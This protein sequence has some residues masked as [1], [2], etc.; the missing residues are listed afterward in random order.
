MIEDIKEV[1]ISPLLALRELDL[2]KNKLQHLEFVSRLTELEVSLDKNKVLKLSENNLTKIVLQ[3]EV[4]L[5]WLYALD[6]S[7]NKIEKIEGIEKNYPALTVLDISSNLI[8]DDNEFECF[9]FLDNIAE[10]ELDDNP[11]FDSGSED[12]WHERFDFLERIN[13]RR[14]YSVG[15]RE[16]R[17]MAQ[18]CKD[19]LDQDLV[20]PKELEEFTHEI[21]DRRRFDEELVLDEPEGECDLVQHSI[22]K[23]NKIVGEEFARNNGYLKEFSQNYLNDFQGIQSEFYSHLSKASESI[24]DGKQTVNDSLLEIGSKPVFGPDEMKKPIFM[25][26]TMREISEKHGTEVDLKEK[27]PN[28][29]SPEQTTSNKEVEDTKSIS[30]S[31]LFDQKLKSSMVVAEVKTNK[32]RLR[33]Y[34]RD[35]DVNKKPDIS[36][37]HT[38]YQKVSINWAQKD[39]KKQNEEILRMLGR[40]RIDPGQVQ[41]VPPR[42]LKQVPSANRLGS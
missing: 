23:K 39:Y 27:L 25:T 1:E 17:K 35:I 15:E 5:P 16:R 19:M 21:K 42:T 3:S 18:I 40:T 30:S 32:F 13:K 6:V 12:I 37:Q 38:V 10:L 9:I 20:S 28:K 8:K 29:L 36:S 4:E 14:F 24:L 11:C 26:N 7:K 33:T 34:S 22:F 41:R 31:S 2:S